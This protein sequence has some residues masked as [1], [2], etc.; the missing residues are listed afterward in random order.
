MAV[1]WDKPLVCPVVIGRSGELAAIER[2]FAHVRDGHGL[3]I[4]VAGEAG[5]GKSRLVAEAR[6]RAEGLGF[7]C[8]QGQ[9][10]ELD[11]V[12]PYAP[13]IDLLQTRVA[14]I[15]A[16]EL[17][18]A[19]G[20][21]APELSWL[22]PDL[23]GHRAGLAPPA[24]LEPEQ[25]KR[26][27]FHALT[28]FILGLAAAQPVLVVIED[29]HWSDES[30]LEFLLHLVRRA[31]ATP[32]LLLLSYRSGEDSPGLRH[33][34]AEL[35]RGR[36]ARELELMRLT[37]AGV[38]AMLQAIFAPNR[39]IRADFLDALY[40]LTEGNPFFIEEVLTSLVVASDRPDAEGAWDRQP[41]DA[42]R[43]P[44]SVQDTVWRRLVRVSAPA[45]QLLTLAAVAGQRFD[46]SLL[47]E[48]A[49][50]TEDQLLRHI[51]EL[52]AAQLVVEET[53]ERFAFRHAL[54][55][56][57][58]YAQLLA[59]ERQA[60]HRTIVEA[61]E[62]RSVQSEAYLPDLAYHAY[63]AGMW[64]QA[65][66]YG[67]CMGEWAQAMHTPQAALT[68]F[69]HA[70][71]A[72]HQLGQPP[73]PALLQARG[74][75]Y[76]LLGHFEQAHNDYE[77][78]LD[79]AQAAGDAGTVWQGLIDLGFLW[80][81]R[82]YNLGGEFLGRALAQAERMGDP[83][84]HAHSLNRLGNWHVNREQPQHG[85]EL[86]HQALVIFEQLGDQRGV[87]ETL[88]L[89]ALASYFRGDRRQAIAWYED[90]AALFRALQER[91]AL[92]SMLTSLGHL[93]CAS[94]AF[95]TMSGA[96]P[97]PGKALRE[98]EEALAIAREI[99]WRSGEAYA[100][101]QLALCLAAAGEYG[102][103]LGAAQEGLAIAEEIGHG[104]WQAFAHSTLAIISLDLLD[105]QAVR[106]HAEPGYVLARETGSCYSTRMSGAVLVQAYLLGQDVASAEAIL[107]ELAVSDVT[108][109]THAQSVV[110]A[111][112]GEF[113]LAR[114][115]PDMALRVADRL[116]AWA[117]A[118]GGAGV[119]P[120]LWKLRGEALAA[121]GE[122]TA[123][124]MALRAAQE[125]A[126]EQ[127]ARPLLWRI[128]LSLGALLQAH[129][130]RA[131]AE[132]AYAASWEIIEDLAATV[133]DEALRE[134]FRGR[135]FARIPSLRRSSSASRATNQA[136][137]GLTAR[138]RE[139]AALIARGMSNRE[140]AEALVVSERTV[141]THI[142]HIRDKLTFTSR[143]QIAA[144]AVQQ[145]LVRD[146]K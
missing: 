138:E 38:E 39:P 126:R 40:A 46:F 140:I 5:V 56:Q 99:G 6:A 120:R 122:A 93:R 51:K 82:N 90:A 53:A 26:R 110:L 62:R 36:L 29:L 87:A 127:G 11:A 71:H 43:I 54:T 91:Q 80:Q 75:A 10:F 79:A 137:G 129:A 119:V 104:H 60:L 94:R 67:R 111:A 130:R 100:L 4:V 84:R 115:D 1:S 68:H 61:L 83:A 107:K 28:Q 42:L 118:A 132:Q 20:V 113:G 12:L 31:A 59:R 74:Q 22:L 37:R 57:A 106:R 7:L 88:D 124:E 139:V 64:K 136:Y 30:S 24:P 73:S 47:Q 2:A 58:I 81:G 142:S 89:L 114:G 16:E 86:H 27:L 41:L 133:P 17:T 141:E 123:A 97:G 52:V 63:E 103:A 117:E 145:G 13:L 146:A 96:R 116:I 85:Q 45:Q 76:E 95:D 131:E 55:R 25:E 34:R 102:R 44:R 15:S 144:W 14:G 125:A 128:Y 98:C 70:L 32:L 23:T 105:P 135:A 72:A 50:Q 9:C 108:I 134:E 92:A 19:L 77:R 121:L 78:A 112:Y 21:A 143:A 33:F 3:T 48:L 109:E 101:N 65:L 49:G 69:S 18:S 35:D 8:L 66:H